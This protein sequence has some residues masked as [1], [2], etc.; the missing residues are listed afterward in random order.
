MKKFFSK[1]SKNKYLLIGL[2]IFFLVRI[3]ILF[4]PPKYY[5]DV[6]HFYERYANMWWYG[7][8]PYLKHLFEY[9][10]A[11]IPLI[12]I[13]LAL[14]LGGLGTYYPNYR[15]Q[16]FLIETI[17]YFFILK[18]LKKSYSSNFQRYA[19]IV[20]YNIASLIAKDFWY[21]GIDIAFSASLALSLL[22]FYFLSQKKFVHKVLFW[23][24]FWLSVAIKFVTLPL[25]LPFLVIKSKKKGL[26][27]EIKT[28]YVGFFLVWGLP[29]VIF[30]SSLSVA[31]IFHTSRP[32]HASSFPAF[33]IY[34]INQFTQSE[35]MSQLEW[36]GPLSQK[37]LFWSF[38]FLAINT[39][40][41]VCWAIIKWFS[42]KGR[43]RS[44]G[45]NVDPYVLMVKTSIIYLL[46]FM[47]ASKIMSPPFHIWYTLLLM[48]LPYKNKKT[49]LIFFSLGIWSLIFNTTNVVK[50]PETI[51][52]YP[53]NWQYLRQVFRFPPLILIAYLLIKDKRNK[54]ASL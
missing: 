19:P 15:I 38:L 35:T 2:L 49:Q 44:A 12:I 17:V 26:I 41:V 51:M 53:F 52:I 21:E 46:A 7:L 10:P 13:P 6:S 45:K 42:S 18:F 28:S 25:Y 9:P 14:D 29:L 54:S 50:L 24:L 33:I 34:T 4:N 36:F 27:E 39:L 31:V 48:L 5:S 23:F 30:R 32:L 20:F 1:I 3:F 37:A 22:S 47:M 40:L 8:P 16:I 11:T 43:S